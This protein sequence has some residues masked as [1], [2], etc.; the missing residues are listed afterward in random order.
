MDAKPRNLGEVLL[1]KEVL[2]LAKLRFVIERQRKFGG[3][4]GDIAEEL[5]YATEEQVAR[6]RADLLDLPYVDLGH[7]IMDTHLLH[8]VSKMYLF[9]YAAMPIELRGDGKMLLVVANPSASTP[10]FRR[11]EDALKVKIA[12]GIS[13]KSAIIDRLTRLFGPD[14]SAE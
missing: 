13:T 12:L 8:A 5:G 10:I 7:L 6:C 2:N 4:L 14:L 3:E 9:K 11:F 1:V